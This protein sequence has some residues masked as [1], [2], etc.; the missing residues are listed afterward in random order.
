VILGTREK[1]RRARY[2]DTKDERTLPS[3]KPLH[4]NALIRASG[5][6]RSGDR[7]V[8]GQEELGCEKSNLNSVPYAVKSLFTAVLS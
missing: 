6:E 5:C 8:E 7:C 4:E 2:I 3:K 1:V